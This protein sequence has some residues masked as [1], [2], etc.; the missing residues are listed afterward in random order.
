M[1]VSSL[2]SEAREALARGGIGALINLENKRKKLKQERKER[3]ERAKSKKDIYKGYQAAKIIKAEKRAKRDAEAAPN[4]V[5]ARLRTELKLNT[6]KT[7]R[8]VGLT[9]K[10]KLKGSGIITKTTKT[11]SERISI[12]TPRKT[13]ERHK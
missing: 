10:P 8:T 9:G 12:D 13:I 6:D 1:N 7:L 3:K 4:R 2:D 5:K 11:F